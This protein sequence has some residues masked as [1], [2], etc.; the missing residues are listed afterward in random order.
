[1]RGCGKQRI[2]PFSVKQNVK[3]SAEIVGEGA[4]GRLEETRRFRRAVGENE[5]GP[6]DNIVEV[7]PQPKDPPRTQPKYKEKKA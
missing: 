6:T 1:M 7:C 3:M 4:R 5:Q 2:L